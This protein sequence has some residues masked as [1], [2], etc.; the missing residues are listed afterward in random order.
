MSLSA[1]NKIAFVDGSCPR[2]ST[3]DNLAILRQWDRC[4]NIVISWLTSSL[5]PV[6]AE[7]VQYSETTERIWKQLERRYVAVN[8]TKK[9]WD[10]LGTMRNNHGN[11]CT[12]ASK[13]GIQKDEEEDKL[14]QFLMGL[15]EVYVGFRKSS[16]FSANMNNNP[17]SPKQYNQKIDFD[18]SRGNVFYKYCKKSCHTIDKYYKL[19]GFPQNFK[20]NKGKRV[21]TN[22]STEIGCPYPGLKSASPQICNGIPG[23]PYDDQASSIPGLT[24]QQYSQ[25]MSLLQQTQISYDSDS[26]SNLMASANFAGSVLSLHVYF[27]N[28]SHA[29]LLSGTSISEKVTSIGSV[30]LSPSL[31]LHQ[32]LLEL[33]KLDQ[34]LYNL[35]HEHQSTPGSSFHKN[36]QPKNVFDIFFN[37]VVQNKSTLNSIPLVPSNDV[38]SINKHDVLWHHRMRHISI[39]KMKLIPSISVDLSSKQSFVCPVCPLARQNRVPF[40]H[41]TSISNSLDKLDPRAAPYVLVGYLFGKKGYKLYN[42]STRSIFVSRDVVFHESIFPFLLSSPSPSSPVPS[43]PTDDYYPFQSKTSSFPCSIPSSLVASSDPPAIPSIP[44]PSDLCSVPPSEVRR[45]IMTHTLP[46]HLNNFITQL[47]P[48]LS[49]STSTSLS[50]TQIATTEPHSYT[51]H[52]STLVCKLQ[53]SLYGLKQASHQW[54]AKLSHALCSRGYISSLNDYSLFIKKSATSTVF[55]AVYVDDIIITGDYLHEIS[56]LKEFLNNQFKIKDLGLLNYFLGIEV[57]YDESGVILHQ[58]KFI[59]DLLHEF[60]CDSI[61]AVVSPVE[62]G[63]KLKSDD[64]ELLPRPDTYRSLVGKLNF[65]THTKPDLCFTVQ[66]FSQFLK[67]LRVPHMNAALHILRYLKGTPNVGIFLNIP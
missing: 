59:A 39:A 43:I 24:K 37:K 26:Q 30:T 47:P 36:V 48:S 42:L 6:I 65:L 50:A 44:V 54:Y 25:L 40:S 29:C 52:T 10:E 2:P 61:S 19:H 9:L 3:N 17:F 60:N 34:G 35:L 22:V 38:H 67:C 8:G 11:S 66:H 32:K 28:D 63:V 12:C 4:N 27:D 49:R 41:S 57:L 58:R 55:L 5:S 13:P 15:N 21:A 33:G 31:T 7:S 46:S 20:F 45:N 16:S 51:Q 14:H 56:A 64:E 1:K 23:P 53:K 18:Q 62:L